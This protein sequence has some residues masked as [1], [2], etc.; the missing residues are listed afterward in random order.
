MIYC[1]V[2]GKRQVTATYKCPLCHSICWSQLVWFNSFKL[3]KTQSWQ[4][5]FCPFT[6]SHPKLFF[7]CHTVS[8]Y[9]VK[10]TALQVLL[11]FSPRHT[12]KGKRG[13]GGDMESNSTC[14]I[15]I[16][17]DPLFLLCNATLF[18]FFIYLTE[19]RDSVFLYSEF[20]FVLRFLL[21]QL[22]LWSQSALWV[23]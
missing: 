22:F 15:S 10:P 3:F 7:F 20:V 4:P 23:L 19:L 12:L 13:N 14:E 5:S 11:C 18:F 6:F 2:N 9:S 17:T 8:H 16:A 21:P 1:F